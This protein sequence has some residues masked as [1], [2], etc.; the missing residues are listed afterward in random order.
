MTINGVMTILFKFFIVY[1][2][3]TI[4]LEVFFYFL[5]EKRKTKEIAG[6]RVNIFGLLMELDNLTLLAVSVALIRYIFVLWCLFDSSSIGF[7][8]IM[9][10]AIFSVSFGI[11]SKSLK[12][13]IFEI[14]TSGAV[15][16]ALISSRLLTNYLVEVRYEWYV[17]AGDVMLKLFVIL[18]ATFFLLRNITNSI[19]K[20]KYIRKERNDEEDS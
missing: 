14:F 20:T 9:I 4:F 7:V 16:F 13:F 3:F 8:H 2:L 11:F 1:S 18:Y 17:F 10:L 12:N 6:I 5:L 15:Y 19:V